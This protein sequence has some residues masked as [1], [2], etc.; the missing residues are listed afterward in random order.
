MHP[1]S[2]SRTL[3]QQSLITRR[4]GAGGG[5]E[6]AG[7]PQPPRERRRAALTASP[8]GSSFSDHPPLGGPVEVASPAR[9]ALSSRKVTQSREREALPAPGSCWAAPEVGA[10]KPRSSCRAVPQPSSFAMRHKALW[11]ALEYTCRLL[12]IS[13][14]AGKSRFSLSLALKGT[15]WELGPPGC[16]PA[17]GQLQPRP[18]PM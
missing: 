9:T 5:R 4:E 12:G 7:A 8:G 15:E 16:L 13:T 2:P 6:R 1:C 11:S 3:P 17:F 10:L 18:L 14:A